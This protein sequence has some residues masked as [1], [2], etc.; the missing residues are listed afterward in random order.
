MAKINYKI[1]K[2]DIKL[3][4]LSNLYFLFGEEKFLI[5]HFTYKIIEKVIGSPESINLIKFNNDFFDFNKI[6]NAIETFPVN[7]K[8]KCVIIDS[9]FNNMNK[10]FYE[11]FL[12]IL[13]DIPDFCILIIQDFSEEDEVKNQYYL[14]LLKNI[15]KIGNI[16]EFKKDKIATERQAIL[17]AKKFNKVLETNEAKILCKRCSYDLNLIKNEIKKLC[18]FSNEEKI[19]FKT[20]E[21]FITENQECKIF[22]LSKAIRNKDAKVALEIVE[23]LLK[24]EEPVKI[25]ATIS[26]DFV[27]AHRIN[28]ANKFKIKIEEISKIFNYEKKEFRLKN[29]E[30]ICKNYEVNQCIKALIHADLLIKTTKIFPYVLICELILDLIFKYSRHREHIINLLS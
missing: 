13:Q 8:K 3:N 17:W 19:S 15:S 11:Q 14:N 25:L 9:K 18:F 10:N 5:S 7:S 6:L 2:N 4:K 27:D 16:V 26:M 29:A 24:Y 12:K 1:L 20:I 28:I 22:D 23:K 21:T 30:E